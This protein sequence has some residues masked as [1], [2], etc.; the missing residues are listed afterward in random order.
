MIELETPRGKSNKNLVI[1]LGGWGELSENTGWK[2]Q[3]Y[4]VL[5]KKAANVP[6][7]FTSVL[8]HPPHSLCIY[9]IKLDT[10]LSWK[11]SDICSCHSREYLGSWSLDLSFPGFQRDSH[12]AW[13]Y[14]P[15]VFQFNNVAIFLVHNCT[16][17]WNSQNTLFLHS[18]T[19]SLLKIK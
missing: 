9:N 7:W 3:K 12:L 15:L 13:A 19:P 6:W 17:A 18:F 4:L 10:C 8:I 1:F 16:Q 2:M 14:V 5:M 11:F